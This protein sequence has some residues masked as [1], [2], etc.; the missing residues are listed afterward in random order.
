MR[1]FIFSVRQLGIALIAVALSACNVG[2]T[3][4][5]GSENLTKIEVALPQTRIA[6]G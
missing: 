1:R 6:L 5:I 2:S 3:N 4:T